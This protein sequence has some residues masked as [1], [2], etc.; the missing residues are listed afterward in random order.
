[1]LD[2]A[3]P[4][5]RSSL[6]L[7]PDRLR[8]LVGCRLERAD[9]HGK[10]LFLR[11]E[12]GLTLHAHQGVSGSWQ[13]RGPAGESARPLGGAWV[14]LRGAAATVAEFGGPR[15][16]LRT[17]AELRAD[18][19]LASLGPDVL[20]PQFEV[21]TGV[22]ALRGAGPG[23][24][25]GEALLDQRVLAGIGN[26]YKSEACFAARIDPADR[27]GE[28]SDDELSRVVVEAASLMRAGLETGARPHDVY[29]RAGRPCLRCGA[30]IRS[31]RQGEANR[32]TYWCPL[33]QR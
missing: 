1:L 18:R 33:C 21:D 8:A 10:H 25:L 6:R 12:N 29:R 11:F 27:I 17:E 2:A 28:L 7:S 23:R 19:R 3:A 24:E 15:L 26:V 5:P 22:A 31:R 16:A 14:V 13:I 32:V 30:R 9:A 20:D 4:N